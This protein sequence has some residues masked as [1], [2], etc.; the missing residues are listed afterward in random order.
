MAR[1]EFT[2]RMFAGDSRKSDLEYGDQQVIMQH[3]KH[4]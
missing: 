1:T 3:E 4:V 2:H